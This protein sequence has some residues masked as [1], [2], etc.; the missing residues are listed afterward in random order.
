MKK[1]I[2]SFLLAIVATATMAQTNPKPGYVITNTGDTIRGVIDFRTNEKLSKQCEFWANGEKEVKV[3]QPGDIEGFRFDNN[4]KYFV[5]RRLN[6]TG[7]PELYFAEFMVQGKMN[8]Y[9]VTYKTDEYY[10][11]ER[12]DGEMA[13]LTNRYTS[14]MSIDAAVQ[15]TKDIVK[16]K[17]RQYGKVKM[18]LQQSKSA[19]ADMDDN[20][21]TRKK[22]VNV[23]RDYHNEVCTDGSSCMVYEYN[24]KTDRVKT[25]LKAFAGFAY[26]STEMTDMQSD[27]DMNFP[28][29]TYEIGVGV[30]IDL[31]RVM[32]DFSVEFGLGLT[33]KYKSTCEEEGVDKTYSYTY[34]KSILTFAVGGVKRFGNGKIRP[35]VRAGGFAVAHLSA[36]E[37]WGYKSKYGSTSSAPNTW[38]TSTHFGVYVGGGVQI[39]VGKHFARVHADLYKSLEP[40]S[41]GQMTKWALTAEFAL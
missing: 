22:L 30:E 25:H 41:M 14:Y 7:T 1:S 40:T 10:F 24:E 37:T 4:G 2:I 26:Y 16:E 12:E 13:E 38:G 27:Q 23:V 34:E 35:I 6:V 3:Y 9:C 5:A 17:K 31:E 39:P 20:N 15:G 36:Q 32:K 28:G 11:F 18:L 21:M 33:P 8:L 29:S 19:V